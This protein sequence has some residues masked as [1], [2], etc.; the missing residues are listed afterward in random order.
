MSSRSAK[1]KNGHVTTEEYEESGKNVFDAI[2]LK[3]KSGN[4]GLPDYSHTPN[5]KYIK[6]NSDGTFRE[7]RVHDENGK[8]IFE[9]GY[10]AEESLTNNRH[11]KVL[12]YHYI[13]DNFERSPAIKL[14]KNTS[15]YDEYKKYL[16]EYGL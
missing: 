1:T 15:V 13:G 7:M 9:I 11:E 4:H 3:G 14:E 2:V 16:E 6:E 5:R 10:H 8:A 12:H